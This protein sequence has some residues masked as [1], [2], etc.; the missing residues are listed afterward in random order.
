MRFHT[1]VV[2]ASFWHDPDLC[3]NLPF[4]GRIMY[5]GL[6][7]LAD[8]SFCIIDSPA[9]FKRELFLD[10]DNANVTKITEWRDT[11]VRLGKLVP[12]EAEGKQC[13]WIRNCHEHQ[14]VDKPS[15]PRPGDVPLPRWVQW[16][17]G[18]SRSTNGYVVIEELVTGYVCDV[19]ETSS[20]QVADESQAC[21]CIEPRTK[22]PEPEK[23][24]SLSERAQAR[25][26]AAATGESTQA[27]RK[28]RGWH[29]S[30][31]ELK[32]P[33][34]AWRRAEGRRGPPNMLADEALRALVGGM[35]ED[36]VSWI[37]GEMARRAQLSTDDPDWIGDEAAYAAGMIDR[38]LTANPPVMTLAQYEAR[39]AAFQERVQGK[40]RAAP[41]E[42]K[43]QFING[44][45]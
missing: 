7:A 28:L 33:L 37:V 18:H 10:E 38:L 31:P 26:E 3:D 21:R 2:K 13:L 22:N 25:D 43:P 9:T 27:P 32:P 29:W 35:A 45:V 5:E 24:V 39:E 12:Y 20:G 14:R 6:W 36:L 41:A 23:I 11:L 44:F 15:A 34:A 8:D 40:A 42:A 16:R 30:A 1:R 17:P 4:L 19:S